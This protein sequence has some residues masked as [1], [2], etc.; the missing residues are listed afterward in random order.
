[1]VAACIGAVKSLLVRGFLFLLSLLPTSDPEGEMGW[2]RFEDA[3]LVEDT[4]VEEVNPIFGLILLIIFVVTAV[5]GIIWLLAQLRRMKLRPAAGAQVS[6]PTVPLPIVWSTH[7]SSVRNWAPPCGCTSSVS[8]PHG[9]PLL[10]NDEKEPL[11]QLPQG[12]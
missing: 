3:I 12:F 10:K 6:P 2:T 4:P 8:W 5:A 7:P 1:M 9:F 11:R